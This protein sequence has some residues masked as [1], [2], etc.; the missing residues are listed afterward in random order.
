MRRR[1]AAAGCRAIGSRLNPLDVN[2]TLHLRPWR[3]TLRARLRWATLLHRGDD[4]GLAR[5]VEHIIQ[6]HRIQTS[7]LAGARKGRDRFDV[8]S[9]AAE[10]T[11]RLPG[12]VLEFG[13]FQ[14]ITLRHLAKAIGPNR[15]VTGFDTFEGLPDDWGT[16][17]PKG[18]FAT[19]VPSLEGCPNVDLQVGRIE[20]T[21]PAFLAKSRQPVSMVHIDVPYYESNVFILEHVLPHMAA[22]SIVVFDEYY[23]YPSYEDHEFKAWSEIRERL[24]VVATPVAYSSRSA[25]FE[26]VDNPLG[27][28]GDAGHVVS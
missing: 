5:V 13:V 18:T 17:L 21:L 22:H 28:S 3:W 12:T 8:L 15:R 23:G 6:S 10:K 20:R 19:G 25:A 11:G 16:L 27:E 9:L 4:D 14:G 26:L 2:S 7:D 1:D 24:N